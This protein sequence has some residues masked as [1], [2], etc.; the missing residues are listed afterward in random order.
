MA[1][2]KTDKN[3]KIM[4]LSHGTTC[5]I[6]QAG[7]ADRLLDLSRIRKINKKQPVDS[8]DI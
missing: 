1:L 7:K 6:T 4:K 3:E 8:W 5:L 2:S